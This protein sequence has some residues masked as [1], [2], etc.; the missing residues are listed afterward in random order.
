MFRADLCE[1]QLGLAGYRALHKASVSAHIVHLPESSP[2]LELERFGSGYLCLLRHPLSPKTEVEEVKRVSIRLESAGFVDSFWS[3]QD[4]EDMKQSISRVTFF[5]RTPNFDL[6]RNT[7]SK[8]ASQDLKIDIAFPQ[9][10]AP[11]HIRIFSPR[12]NLADVQKAQ[13]VRT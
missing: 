4:L 8:I 11:L 7:N 12:L 10:N 13:Q 6:V 5:T 2:S 1:K 9:Y 3:L